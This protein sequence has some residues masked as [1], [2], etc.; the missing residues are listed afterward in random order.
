[1]KPRVFVGSSSEKLEVALAIQEN[2]EERMEVTVWPQGVFQPSRPPLDSLVEQ[3]SRSDFGVFVFSPDDVLIMREQQ[4]EAVRDN[5]LFELGLLVG[6]LGRRRGFI[7]VPKSVSTEFHL[8]SDLIG[9]TPVTYD[10][11][12]QDGNLKAALGPACQQIQ[13]AVRDTGWTDWSEDPQ[14]GEFAA[15]VR[16]HRGIRSPL[17]VAAA[18]CLL[19]TTGSIRANVEDFLQGRGWEMP[20]LEFNLSGLHSLE[21]LEKLVTGLKQLR[22]R[23]DSSRH[24]EI[25]LFLAG[26]IAAGAVVGALY[27][28]WIPVKLYQRPLSPP[29]ELYE[30]WLPLLKW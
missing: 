9:M 3:L 21:D 1:M 29:P 14:P 24:T 5:V 18:I 2:L 23:I 17:P 16:S 6:R 10:D 15:K 25:H 26:P 11:R 28:N 30:Y 12:R 7:V 19:P 27:S 13:R 4:K 22:R 8:P 20:I